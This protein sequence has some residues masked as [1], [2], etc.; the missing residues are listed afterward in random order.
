[1]SLRFLSPISKY[2]IVVLHDKTQRLADG[3]T[4]VLE[5]GYTVEFKQVP[6]M[7]WEEAEARARLSFKGVPWKADRS[8]LIDPI[9]RV[10]MFDTA[11]IKDTV[12]RG[13]V[14]KALLANPGLNVSDSFIQIHKP[15]I[16]AP[17][18]SYDELGP[19]GT[20]TY[21]HV[22]K[23]NIETAAQI[24]VPLDQ[25]IA[26]ERDNRANQVVLEAYEAAN[27]PEEIPEEELVEA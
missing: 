13:K 24:G 11:E 25:L 1:M 20:R 12:L 27:A 14:E 3:T 21:A 8:G 7:P 18:P 5:N 9:V 26:Y 16:P 23:Q 2:R 15:E 19:K 6:L 10:S 17:W 4:N 22:A